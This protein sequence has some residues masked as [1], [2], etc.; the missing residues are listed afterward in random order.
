[1]MFKYTASRKLFAALEKLEAPMKLIN[2]RSSFFQS[3]VSDIK[4]GRLSP[5]DGAKCILNTLYRAF[6]RK[7]SIN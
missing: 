5:D 1:M 7:A 3:I 6:D 4:S 2:V